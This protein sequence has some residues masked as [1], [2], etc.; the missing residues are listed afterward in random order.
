MAFR[1]SHAISTSPKGSGAESLDRARTSRSVC[2]RVGVFRH[3]KATVFSKTR[4]GT[5]RMRSDAT[6][7]TP[8]VIQDNNCHR[9]RIFHSIKCH[10][11]LNTTSHLQ[12]QTVN[13]MV[14]HSQAPHAGLFLNAD[15]SSDSTPVIVFHLDHFGYEVSS[16]NHPWVGVAAS[17]DKL[18]IARLC[19]NYRQQVIDR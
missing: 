11:F 1:A 6:E 17:D 8:I 4:R 15:S 19:I 7:M 12:T 10:E 13:A 2:G 9:M 3:D 5:T 14:H 16:V 18:H